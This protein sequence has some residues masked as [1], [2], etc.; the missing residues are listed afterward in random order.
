M[1]A[2][3]EQAYRLAVAE[4]GAHLAKQKPH[5]AEV[6]RRIED[7]LRSRRFTNTETGA[8]LVS[9]PPETAAT[10]QP[11]K[12]PPVEMPA[13]AL[14]PRI[15]EV[16][17]QSISGCGVVGELA[18]AAILY[19]VI[20]ARLLDKPVS[21][22]VKGL[23]SSGKSFTTEKTVEFFPK[24]AVIVMTAMSERALIYSKED[25]AHRTLIL[26]E[27]TALR[28]G[29]EDNLTAYFVRS[30]LSEGR[31]DYP[32]TIRDPAGGFM[33]KTITK[34]GPTGLILT[35]TK[36]RVHAENETRL[37]SLTTND[38]REQTKAIFHALADETEKKPNLEPWHQLQKWLAESGTH[39]VTI[40]YA[41]ALARMVP[42]VAVRLRRDFGSVLNLIRAHAIL[43][44][45]TRTKDEQGRIV[46]TLEDYA[47]VR[48]L[49]ADI[50][51]EGVGETV[52]PTIR[53]T[54]KAVE[55][56][57]SD[58]GVMAVEIGKHLN[59]DKGTVSRRLSVAAAGGY[60]RNLEDKRGKPG[61][62]VI[63]EPMPET[64]TLLPQ[65]QQLENVLLGTSDQQIQGGCAVA[66]DIQG[67]K[68]S[69]KTPPS[70]ALDL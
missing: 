17:K 60:L 36:P 55:K 46:A 32:V 45:A 56:L 11:S 58:S 42:P 16:F 8:R 43:H 30:L 10:A 3:S 23:S 64:N 47:Q 40:P 5:H 28:E 68:P 69:P 2:G 66:V 48:E 27:A 12:Q 70:E 37:L 44:Q 4:A 54:V 7:V 65:P 62:W 33:T 59:L 67:V 25:Y 19:L 18:T 15:L 41:T 1:D 57:R 35:T 51:A 49:V 13:I 9:I 22:A 61:R 31:I 39:T 63:G 21:A 50:V 52:S 14:S 38:T 20:T 6:L 34:K 53:E 24:E 26:Y 29:P